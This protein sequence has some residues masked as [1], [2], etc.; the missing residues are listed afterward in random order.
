M[1]GDVS[2][3]PR[4]MV[5][6][7]DTGGSVWKCLVFE[8]GQKGPLS[9][10][11][12]LGIEE[13]ADQGRRYFPGPDV[14]PF[15]PLLLVIHG[16]LKFK[17][18]RSFE[19]ATRVVVSEVGFFEEVGFIPSLGFP[20]LCYCTLVSPFFVPEDYELRYDLTRLEHPSRRNQCSTTC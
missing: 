18:R 5:T 7:G 20:P 8:T 13:R 1:T 10:L 11:R 2:T 19:I 9:A 14:L 17:K 16:R 4:R 15:L 6:G 3:D 12:D